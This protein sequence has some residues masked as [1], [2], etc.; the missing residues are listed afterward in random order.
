MLPVEPGSAAS[1][2][3]GRLELRAVRT[4]R[5]PC[6]A[7]GRDWSLAAD[8]HRHPQPLEFL[9]ERSTEGNK[10]TL[11]GRRIFNRDARSTGVGVSSWRSFA[12]TG[13]PGQIPRHDA[14]VLDPA[15][16]PVTP[17]DKS[18]SH[19]KYRMCGIPRQQSVVL[20]NL[21]A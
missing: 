5:N 2:L 15:S 14:Q 12:A 11:V 19:P 8:P 9:P 10:G 4:E 7:P 6:H 1:V 13:T 20:P 21:S 16:E 18:L 3:V 17:G